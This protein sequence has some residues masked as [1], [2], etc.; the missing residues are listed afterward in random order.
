M[1]R[2]GFR[3]GG[4]KGSRSSGGGSRSAARRSGGSASSPGRRSS[5][6]D[7]SGGKSSQEGVVAYSIYN[8]RGKRTYVGST[9]N[10]ERRATQ[11]AKSGKLTRG[12]KLVVES[13]SMSRSAAQRL[14]AKKIQGY[15][16]RT[17]QLPRHNRTSDGQ[18]RIWH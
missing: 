5:N 13:K 6:R 10:P 2:F 4:F 14:E 9:N 17:G 3:G 7:Q 16:S 1:A 18:Y 12:S 15:R 11:H 8:S